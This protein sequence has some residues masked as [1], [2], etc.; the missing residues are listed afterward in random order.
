MMCK[1]CIWCEK[2]QGARADVFV[3]EEVIEVYIC[4]YYPPG[5]AVKADW[6]CSKF[7]MVH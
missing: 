1:E 2:K 6:W 3:S 5:Q 7:E 4:H